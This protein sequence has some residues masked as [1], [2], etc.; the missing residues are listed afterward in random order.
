MIS[1]SASDLRIR[2]GASQERDPWAAA[3]ELHAAI[4]A[5]DAVL[6]IVFCSPDY[7]RG[8]L[9]AALRATFGD[10]AV[11]G[12][13]TAGEIT[14][15]GYVEG[16][17]TGVSFAGAG[18]HAATV[19]IDRL[20][21]LELAT[22]ET[23]TARA[24]EEL[25]SS[26]GAI[27]SAG[28][29]FGFLLVDG[30]AA[31]EEALVAG[32]YGSLGAIPLFGGSAADGR[33]FEKTW[34]YHDGA[35]RSDCA[36]L[37]LISPGVPFMVFK[38]EGFVPSTTKMVVTAADLSRRV[39]T[40]LD[41]EPAAAE[42]ARRVGVPVLEL[43]PEV[44]ASHPVV[45]TIGGQTFVR[46]IQKVNDDGSLT[47]LCAIDEGIVLTLARGID[48]LENLE[49]AFARLE[50]DLGGKPSVVLG[51]DCILRF[52]EAGRVGV[53]ARIGAVLQANNVVGF[54][55]YGEQWN[56]MHV[57]QTFTGVALG[58]AGTRNG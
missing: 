12:C 53:R 23:A 32:L 54:A 38:T 19:R 29:A 9:A 11:V 41:G 48:M 13:T 16:A 44:F 26:C 2:R 40:E 10:A 25:T 24:L 31:K 22:C 4:G 14:P 37:T 46:S 17:L 56:A 49:A 6:T 55:T 33:R 1:A 39:V 7:D 8:G 52:L 27:P 35:F 51:C 36:L 34:L 20:A 18:F 47:F 42:Y 30:L 45:V 15:E 3:R 28:D 43:A 5:P 21:A 57:N 50:A 58:A